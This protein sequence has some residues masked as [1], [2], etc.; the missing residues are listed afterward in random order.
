MYKSDFYRQR[1]EVAKELATYCR[2]ERAKQMMQKAAERWRELAELAKR[3]RTIR[4]ASHRKPRGRKSGEENSHDNVR[5]RL[6]G[7]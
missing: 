4:A 1:A 5:H 6:S 7:H 3:G 2:D